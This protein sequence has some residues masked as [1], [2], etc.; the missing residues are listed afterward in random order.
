MAVWFEDHW[1]KDDL[2]K[3]VK[4]WYIDIAELREL[5]NVWAVMQ[6]KAGENK[7]REVIEFFESKGIKSYFTPYEQ[8][9]H[10]QGE[11]SINSL[12][13]PALSV[14]VESGLG[15]QFWLSAATVA[16]DARNVTY[17]EHIK[18]TLYMPLAFVRYPMIRKKKDIAIGMPCLCIPECG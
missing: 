7:S 17:K 1:A 8:W 9:Q 5:H 16:K 6:D 18:M 13:T 15:G 10:G 4:K 12:M 14:L 2:L 11:S 3:A